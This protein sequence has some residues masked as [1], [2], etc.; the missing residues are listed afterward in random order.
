MSYVHSGSVLFQKQRVICAEHAQTKSAPKPLQITLHG[1]PALECRV[2]I[3]D[4]SAFALDRNSGSEG[5][6][7]HLRQQWRSLGEELSATSDV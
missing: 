2:D 4:V 3:T 1:K 7:E 5:E 6:S